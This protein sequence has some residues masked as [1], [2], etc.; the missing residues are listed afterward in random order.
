MKVHHPFGLGALVVGTLSL[1][2]FAAASDGPRASTAEE[3]AATD[4]AVSANAA[5]ATCASWTDYITGPGPAYRVYIP[6]T[7]RNGNQPDCVLR[8]GDRGAGVFILQDALIHCYGQRIAQ[9]AIYGDAMVQSIRNVQ[10][11]HQDKGL[12]VDGVY[13]P[14]TRAAMVFSKYKPDG[15]FDHCWFR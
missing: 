11:F 8:P 12:K 15:G 13:G 4:Q 3:W 9:D 6:S 7:T 10:R 2:A 5:A 14:A 1:S